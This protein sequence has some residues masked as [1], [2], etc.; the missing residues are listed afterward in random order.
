V[1]KI[2][3][4]SSSPIPNMISSACP[5]CKVKRVFDRKPTSAALRTDASHSSVKDSARSSQ[6]GSQEKAARM[7]NLRRKLTADGRQPTNL[8]EKSAAEWGG[9]LASANPMSLDRAR[10]EIDTAK[11]S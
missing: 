10:E 1:E 9:A 7:N 3:L 8:K 5:M 2:T 11:R 4:S 6:R